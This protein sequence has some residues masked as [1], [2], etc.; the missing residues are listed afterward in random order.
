MLRK[1][2]LDALLNLVRAR[3]TDK[4]GQL[5]RIRSSAGEPVAEALARDFLATPH[6]QASGRGETYGVNAT[7]VERDLGFD[8]DEPTQKFEVFTDAGAFAT[9]D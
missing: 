4:A 2:S 8:P 3:D 5:E 9:E 7:L 1:A 6:P